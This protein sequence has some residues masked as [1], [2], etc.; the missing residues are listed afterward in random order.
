MSV[1]IERPQDLSYF[2]KE[3]LAR[4]LDIR[5]IYKNSSHIYTLAINRKYIILRNII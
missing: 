1:Y 2:F 5:S 3:R 4:W